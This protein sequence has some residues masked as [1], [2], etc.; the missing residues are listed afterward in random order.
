MKNN[1]V[2]TTSLKNA[3]IWHFRIAIIWRL[4]KPDKNKLKLRVCLSRNALS[5]VIGQ[6]VKNAKI[7]HFKNVTIWRPNK[8]DKNKPK[9]KVRLSRNALSAVIGQN[10]N[11]SHSCCASVSYDHK[12]EHW[13]AVNTCHQNPTKRFTKLNVNFSETEVRRVKKSF[14]KLKKLKRHPKLIGNLNAA[15]RYLMNERPTWPATEIK[16][17]KETKV[18][19]LK[20]D[21]NIQQNIRRIQKSFVGPKM[22]KS[23]KRANN[24][25]EK[26]R[27]RGHKDLKTKSKSSRHRRDE[28]EE[29]EDE[30]AKDP[31]KSTPKNIGDIKSH[32]LEKSIAG[33]QRTIDKRK[34]KGS[35]EETEV[36]K[37]RDA[38]NATV[39]KTTGSSKSSDRQKTSQKPAPS[40]REPLPRNADPTPRKPDPTPRK[41][42]WFHI[43]RKNKSGSNSDSGSSGEVKT[44]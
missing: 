39:S 14:K 31:K 32:E 17:R 6:S 18:P 35:L 43:K 28:K 9:L 36:Q 3:K 10:V 4:N 12:S 25:N 38:I 44:K 41:P 22:P 33:A 7:W 11:N 24:G 19:Y 40:I 37:H 26:P 20:L 27:D 1:K 42:G 29:K 23:H 15:E 21:N 16:V 30:K 2:I 34:G 5:A 13:H 8:P